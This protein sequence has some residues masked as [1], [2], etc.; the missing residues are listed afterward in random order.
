MD[1][2]V[3][4]K[5]SPQES[6]LTV[7]RYHELGEVWGCSLQLRIVDPLAP[8]GSPACSGLANPFF[9]SAQLDDFWTEFSW[10]SILL[11][12]T[13]CC[14]DCDEQVWKRK[15]RDGQSKGNDEIWGSKM[16]PRALWLIDDS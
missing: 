13:C 15:M 11:S 16:Q 4:S 2:V 5:A 9:A 1:F 7:H 3:D 14:C 8:A 10:P 12:L 6:N